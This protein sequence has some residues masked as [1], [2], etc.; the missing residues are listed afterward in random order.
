MKIFIVD[1]LVIDRGDIL[2]L[3]NSELV[4]YVTILLMKFLQVGFLQ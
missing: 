1:I 3:H 4:D 2:Y